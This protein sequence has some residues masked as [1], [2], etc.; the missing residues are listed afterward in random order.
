MALSADGGLRSSADSLRIAHGAVVCW[1][2]A[3]SIARETL[4]LPRGAASVIDP[5]GLLRAIRAASGGRRGEGVESESEEN[6]LRAHR[7]AITRRAIVQVAQKAAPL[8]DEQQ[9]H[10]GALHLAWW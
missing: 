1:A 8:S 2:S 10:A 3:K 6:L 9:S 7:K 5:I 4:V